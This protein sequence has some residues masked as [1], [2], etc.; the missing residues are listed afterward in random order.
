MWITALFSLWNVCVTSAN[1]HGFLYH[2]FSYLDLGYTYYLIIFSIYFVHLLNKSHCEDLHGGKFLSMILSLV[3]TIYRYYFYSS[4]DEI[5]SCLL[6]RQLH[7][8]LHN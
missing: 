6:E 7:N 4:V 2:H 8:I 5:K 3:L 1:V